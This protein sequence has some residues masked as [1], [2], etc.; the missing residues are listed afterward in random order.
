MV[1]YSGRCGHGSSAAPK[2]QSV[3]L[4]HILGMPAASPARSKSLNKQT[5]SLRC[6]SRQVR[7]RS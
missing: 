1:A 6:D 2:S 5:K 4:E 7:A 3:V